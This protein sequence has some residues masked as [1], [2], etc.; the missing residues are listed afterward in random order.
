M[1]AINSFHF[2]FLFVFLDISVSFLT[3]DLDTFDKWRMI[4]YCYAFGKNL[5]RARYLCWRKSHI[6]CS[7][8][9][10]AL[11]WHLRNQN[12]YYWNKFCVVIFQFFKLS[13]IYFFLA[14]YDACDLIILCENIEDEIKLRVKH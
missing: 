6:S 10:I 1:K 11:N 2:F 4:F 3:L 13:F 8:K 9:L 7:G 12:A 5:F 14:H